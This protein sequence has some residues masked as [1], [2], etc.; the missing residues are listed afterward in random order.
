MWPELFRIGPLI[1]SPYGVLVAAA[2]FAGILVAARLASR[3]EHIE[4]ALIWDFSIMLVLVALL[5]AKLLM[6]FTDPFFYEHPANILSVDFIRS[7]GVF[8]G[9]FLAA[10]AFAAWYLRRHRLPAWKVS[11]AFAPAIALGHTFGRLGCLTAGCCHGSPTDWFW[12]ITFTDPGCMVSTPLLGIPLHPT[13][14]LEAVA[15]FVIFLSLLLFYNR[16]KFDGQVILGYILCYSVM[17]F[18]LEFLRGDVSDSIRIGGF[19]VSQLISGL[20]FVAAVCFYWQRS[21]SAR[22]TTAPAD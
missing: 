13:Q 7:A 18:S 11:D 4:P 12:G 6:I 2:F 15:N 1:I 19:S 5:G 21:R 10:L 16:K 3:H 8:Y 9:G 20:C 22:S 17:R 14:L